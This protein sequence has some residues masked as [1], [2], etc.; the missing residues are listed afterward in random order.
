MNT[1]EGVNPMNETLP[2]PAPTCDM[3]AAEPVY[4][5][6]LVDDPP[7]TGR[8]PARRFMNWWQ[9]S[10]RVPAAFKS[11]QAATQAGKDAIV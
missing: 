1:G 8:A 7:T 3:V 10:R 2:I 11:R 4:D 6:E 9:R 5:G